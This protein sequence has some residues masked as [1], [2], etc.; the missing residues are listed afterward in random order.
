[1]S[2]PRLC[3]SFNSTLNDYFGLV[4]VD[5]G[6]MVVDRDWKIK[7]TVT[8]AGG[9]LTLNGDLDFGGFKDSATEKNIDK[10]VLMELFMKKILHKM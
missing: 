9:T 3:I 8:V 2:S 5:K 6:S 7:N 4:S 10:E 1:M